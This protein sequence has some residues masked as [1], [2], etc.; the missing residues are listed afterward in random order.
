MCG[1]EV[2]QVPSDERGG[3]DV[4]ALRRLLDTDV[5]ALMLTNPNTLGLFDENILE[6]TS[7]VHEAGALAY[8]DGAN[9]NAI[10]AGRVRARW[11][12]TRCTSTF[13]RPSPRR[14]AV[15]GRER[16]RWP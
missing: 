7:A 14:T 13:I 5:A 8:C 11:V 1:Y 4:A 6:I 3:V 12:S 2:V 10:M 15:V 9:L 16:D